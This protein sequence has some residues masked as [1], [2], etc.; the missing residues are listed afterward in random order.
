MALDHCSSVA[1]TQTQLQTRGTSAPWQGQW[2]MVFCVVQGAEETAT[3]LNPMP[4]KAATLPAKGIPLL[5]S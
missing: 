3:P 2:H 1:P 5:I 4:T